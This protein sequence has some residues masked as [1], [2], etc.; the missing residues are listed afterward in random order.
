MHMTRLQSG[1]RRRPGFTLI[2]LLVVIALI[3]ILA[4]L[5]LPALARAKEKARRVACLSNLKQTSLS[6][7]LFVVDH[8]RYPWRVP[9]G[10]GGSR[11]RSRVWRHFRVMQ[12]SEVTPKILACPSDVRIPA[13]T[14]TTARDTNISY[15]IGVDNKEDRPGAILVGDHN[16]LGGRARQSCPVADIGAVTIGFGTNEIPRARW[17]AALHQRVGNISIGDGSAQKATK[18]EVQEYFWNS[19]DDPGRSFNNHILKPR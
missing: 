14:F 19:G 5:L 13:E 9:I 12:D 10:E 2:E 17:S 8:G 3:A 1:W 15:F 18:Q 7:H 4:G 16:L 11:T 6:M